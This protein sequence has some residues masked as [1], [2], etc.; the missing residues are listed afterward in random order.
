MCLKSGSE[1]FFPYSFF[2][3]IFLCL[4]HG[5]RDGVSVAYKKNV[6]DYTKSFGDHLFTSV[7]ISKK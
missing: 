7:T 4:Y 2:Y 6:G 3:L 1:I 5:I